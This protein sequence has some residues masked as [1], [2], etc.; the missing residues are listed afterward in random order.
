MPKPPLIET[1]NKSISV[2]IGE[3]SKEYDEISKQFEVRIGKIT[4]GS[5]EKLFVLS[6]VLNELLKL[7]KGQGVKFDL[8]T[9]KRFELKRYK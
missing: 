3:G 6:T 2:C 8:G 5:G 9:S 4:K 7:K 1:P